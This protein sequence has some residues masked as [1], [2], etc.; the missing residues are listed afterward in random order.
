MSTKPVLKKRLYNATL[1][2]TA[3][4]F[5]F[6]CKKGS[7]TDQ[8][9]TNERKV[10]LEITPA[11]YVSI[12]YDDPREL[13]ADEVKKIVQEYPLKLNPTTK[14]TN[15]IKIEVAEKYYLDQ[16][17][18][19]EK[20]SAQAKTKSW[21]N[22]TKIPVY[23]VN[24]TASGK[25]GSALVCSDERAPI[26]LAYMPVNHLKPEMLGDNLM[27]QSSKK[28]I[29]NRIAYL[30][31]LKDSLRTSTLNKLEQKIG[32][33]P[34]HNVF[35][36]VKDKIRVQSTAPKT[37][38][39]VESWLPSQVISQVGPFATTEWDQEGVSNLLLP[40]GSEC[41]HVP[42]GCLVIA[43]AQVLAQLQPTFPIIVGTTTREVF[44]P[45]AGHGGVWITITVP[46][47]ENANWPYL[48]QSPFIGLN[49]EQNKQTM[50][51][52]FIRDVFNKTQTTP[53]CHGSGTQMQKMVDFLRGYID[54]D[55]PASFNVQQIKT[56]LDNNHSVIAAGSR[57][58]GT[59]K[60][61]H[62][63][64][65]DGYAICEKTSGSIPGDLVHQYDLY[66][67]ANLGWGGSE[68][69]WFLVGTDW[70]L[71]F[72][73]YWGERQYGLDMQMALN[74]RSK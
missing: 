72:D 20:A 31:H 11:E 18:K 12:A 62:A 24:L 7:E 26:V 36:Y 28:Y 52:R 35:T 58:S 44:N 56:S 47:Y 61:R 50:Y 6:S 54:I 29:I 60:I 65:V 32:R 71:S 57:L 25:T 63:W 55:N 43:G 19:L 64:V 22:D 42:A 27:Y 23:Q 68:T 70:N 38:S 10:V 37:K 17:G 69:G 5:M 34:D 74:A 67:H 73:V 8:S 2:I 39:P 59:E 49:D 9:I 4:L 15:D 51:S 66:L 3:C 33:L 13:T 53:D 1:V 41:A 45:N 46:L 48:K 14:G 30:R 16:E 40:A 21:I